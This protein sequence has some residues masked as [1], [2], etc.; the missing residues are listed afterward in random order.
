MEFIDEWVGAVINKIRVMPTSTYTLK[1]V[2]SHTVA[3]TTLR[4]LSE[5]KIDSIVDDLPGTV[6]T[7]PVLV[8][9]LGTRGGWAEK[10]YG[11]TRFFTAYND[12]TL[13]DS[14]VALDL[15][16]QVDPIT[17]EQSCRW[18][19]QFCA[20]GRS[21]DF[22]QRDTWIANDIINLPVPATT[23]DTGSK[24]AWTCMSS[25]Q[26]RYFATDSDDYDAGQNCY[27]QPY[28]APAPTAT[29]TPA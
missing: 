9:G 3:G 17:F 25:I 1:R 13:A 24:T 23:I 6:G 16:V 20:I 12:D 8:Y 14:V 21:T 18:L 2:A 7:Q 5:E 10:R 27:W 29:A 26:F 22:V 4:W 28:D 15:Q 11:A 19:L